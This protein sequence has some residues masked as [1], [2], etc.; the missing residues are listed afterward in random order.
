MFKY[1][2]AAYLIWIGIR[3]WRTAGKSDL[4]SVASRKTAWGLLKSGFGIGIGNPKAI[5][6]HASLLP[7][8]FDLRSLTIANGLEISTLVVIVDML[9][10]ASAAA[11]AGSAARLLRSPAHRRNLERTGGAAVIGAGVVLAVR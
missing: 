9:V 5:L 2:G 8:F 11:A 1:A 4:N 7:V 10:L 6:F 3:I